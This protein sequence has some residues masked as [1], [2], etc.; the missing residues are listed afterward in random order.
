MQ[1]TPVKALPTGRPT[2]EI[3]NFQK[4]SIPA[5]APARAPISHNFPGLAKVVAISGKIVKAQ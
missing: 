3:D 4:S 5:R 2:S 1:L